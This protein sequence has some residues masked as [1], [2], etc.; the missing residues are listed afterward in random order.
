MFEFAQPQCMQALSIVGGGY[1]GQ[2]G[3]GA[4]QNPRTLEASDNGRDFKKVVDIT[5]GGVQQIP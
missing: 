1:A 5:L 4:D 2:F 3:F